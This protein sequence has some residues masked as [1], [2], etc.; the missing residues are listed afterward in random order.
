MTLGVQINLLV[1]KMPL[2][3]SHCDEKVMKWNQKEGFVAINLPHG[4]W[5]FRAGLW[6]ECGKVWSCRL[7]KSYLCF[8]KDSLPEDQSAK[9]PH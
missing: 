9:Q 6:E 3:G 4:S 5:A 2:S 7:K 8:N 1:L